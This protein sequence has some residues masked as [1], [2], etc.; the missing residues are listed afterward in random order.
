M[1]SPKCFCELV[2]YDMGTFLKAGLVPD[3][4]LVKRCCW[5]KICNEYELDKESYYKTWDTLNN[6]RKTLLKRFNI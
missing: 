2:N 1:M 4:A 5:R 6:R 3:A